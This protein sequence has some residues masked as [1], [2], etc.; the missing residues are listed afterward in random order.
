MRQYND[1]AGATRAACLCAVTL[2][3][4]ALAGCTAAP[5]PG[6]EAP[7]VTPRLQTAATARLAENAPPQT[8]RP[9]DNNPNR[10]DLRG[11]LRDDAPLRYI[12]KPGDTLWDI[13][14]YYLRKPWYWPQLWHDN[15][16][17]ANPHLIYPGDVLL[18]TT[19]NGQPRLSRAIRLSPR[20]RELPVQ[21]AIATVPLEAIRAF[22]TGP[23]LVS[24]A[25][26]E[27]A[28]YIVAFTDSHLVGGEDIGAYVR[29]APRDGPR[30]YSIVR[31]GEPLID[32]ETGDQIGYQALPIGRLRIERFDDISTA[33]ITRSYREALTGDRLL[34]ARTPILA[35]DFYPHTPTVPVAGRIIAV[36]GGI[37][38]LG[39]YDVVIIN[40]GESDGLER[41]HLLNIY[42]SGREVIDPVEGGEV[43]LPDQKIGL[44]MLF[45]VDDQVSFGV[46]MRATHAV[47]VF[48]TVRTPQP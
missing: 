29:D 22:L 25:E 40:R 43:S 19:V 32:P 48:D 3:G 26:L 1:L 28:P 41:G 13:A 9:N 21:K 17:I 35:S 30:V 39:Q 36:Y 33:R 11:A 24:E 7:S 18:L 23:R 12:V 27:Q 15:P 46:I 37:T 5:P 44:L 2:A 20:V 6:A 16:E 47:H 14:G 10:G 4:L 45:K 38:A 42:E 34:P 8:H 31:P